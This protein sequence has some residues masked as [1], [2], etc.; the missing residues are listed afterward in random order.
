MPPDLALLSTL[1]GSN[2]PC[3]ELIVMVPKVFETF[4]FDCI[5]GRV[6]QR[7]RLTSPANVLIIVRKL[8]QRLKLDMLLD[9]TE[10]LFWSRI[11]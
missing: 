4:K 9:T 5:G 8:N 1:I 7:D 10:I 6:I 2:Y 11:L 3:L